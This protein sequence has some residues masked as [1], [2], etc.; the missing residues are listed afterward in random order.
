[1]SP[2]IDYERGG[3]VYAQVWRAAATA[4][5]QAELVILLGTDH[6]GA[7]ATLTLTR[8][9]YATPWG[10]LPTDVD[11]V[12]ALVGALGSEAAFGEELH[13]RTEHSVELA[14]IWLH[15]IRGGAPVSLLPILC[16]SFAGF[17]NDAGDPAAHPPFQSA[18]ETLRQ[19]KASRRTLVVAAADLAHMGPAFGDRYGLDAIAQAQ[20]RW[21][22]ERLLHSVHAGDAASFF[23]QI[24]SEGDRRHVCGLPPIYLALRLLEAARGSPAGYALCPADAQGMSFVSIAGVTLHC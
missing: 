22:D 23:A 6:N 19:A 13:H 3:R 8:Q 15:F 9:S 24:K 1:V 2:H 20:M 12:D 11:L 16:G 7:D 17:V 14:A 5:R 21:S 4:A 18:L 10:I